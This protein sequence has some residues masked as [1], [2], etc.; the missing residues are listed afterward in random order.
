MA[1][2]DYEKRYPADPA[3]TFAVLTDPK[4]LDA[5]ARKLDALSWDVDVQAGAEGPDTHV[6]LAVPTDGVPSL[7]RRF[8]GP[9]IDVSDRRTWQAGEAPTARFVVEAAL[10]SKKARATGTITLTPTAEGCV[11]RALG[12][13]DVHLPPVS[14]PA[15]AQAV[16]LINSVLKREGEVAGE[17]LAAR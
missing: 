12:D 11:F 16:Q 2:L 8:V 4:F 17:W 9:K 14:G 7:F 1:R 10:G 6:D 15:A 5:Y 13:V 3:T